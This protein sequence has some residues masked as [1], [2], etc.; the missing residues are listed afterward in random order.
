MDQY[1][2]KSYKYYKD[3]KT[4]TGAKRNISLEREAYDFVKSNFS[5]QGFKKQLNLKLLYNQNK[6]LL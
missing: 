5:F 6:H 2:L 4:F 1:I 3:N